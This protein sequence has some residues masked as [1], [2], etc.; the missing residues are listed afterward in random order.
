MGTSTGLIATLVFM[1]YVDSAKVRD[2]YRDPSIL[3][4]V[5]PILMYWLGRIWLL[6]GRGQMRDDPVKFA[7]RDKTSLACAAA[8]VVVAA[9]ARFSPGWISAGLH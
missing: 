1:L 9:A 6:A 2:S 7:L 8:I 5:L 3:W 4:L